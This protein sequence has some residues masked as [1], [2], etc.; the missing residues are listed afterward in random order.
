MAEKLEKLK[1]SHLKQVENKNERCEKK[2]LAILKKIE[3][4]NKKGENTSAS[5]KA[6]AKLE[7]DMKEQKETFEYETIVPL[8][9]MQTEAEF[10]GRSARA[11][12]LSEALAAANA[13]EHEDTTGQDVLGIGIQGLVHQLRSEGIMGKTTKAKKKSSDRSV[14]DVMKMGSHLLK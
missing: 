6:L 9:R 4:L 3:T 12:S 11:K 5:E 2:K 10:E 7:A 14:Q 1:Q 8:A 13:K